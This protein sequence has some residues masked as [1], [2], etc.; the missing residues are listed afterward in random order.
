MTEALTILQSAAT[1]AS[2][3]LLCLGGLAFLWL[4]SQDGGL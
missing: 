2:D 3:L 1:T 4:V